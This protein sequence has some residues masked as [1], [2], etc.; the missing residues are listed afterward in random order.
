MG[1]WG[2][3]WADASKVCV[4]INGGGTRL[5]LALVITIDH[6]SLETEHRIKGGGVG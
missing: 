5:L 6:A 1:G 2:V 3:G 4:R